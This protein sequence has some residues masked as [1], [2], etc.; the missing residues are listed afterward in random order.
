MPVTPITHNFVPPAGEA[1]LRRALRS[2]PPDMSPAQAAAC[3]R[4]AAVWERRR[5]RRHRQRPPRVS[6]LRP[7]ST[8]TAAP[9]RGERGPLAGAIRW[10][11]PGA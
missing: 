6:C 5:H 8:R 10:R 2:P 1:A 9:G 11:K 4:A 7:T 3:R